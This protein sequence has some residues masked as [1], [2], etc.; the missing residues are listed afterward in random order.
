M[1]FIVIRLTNVIYLKWETDI[2]YANG[3]FRIQ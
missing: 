1:F 3:E 2:R